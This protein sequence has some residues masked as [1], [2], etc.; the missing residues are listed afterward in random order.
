[1]QCLKDEYRFLYDKLFFSSLP[2]CSSSFSSL[3]SPLFPVSDVDGGHGPRSPGRVV[4]LR[5]A[6]VL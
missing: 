2:S 6:K 5:L 3:L 4:A 1:M